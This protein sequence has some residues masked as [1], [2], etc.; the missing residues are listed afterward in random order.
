MNDRKV[1]EDSD[2]ERQTKKA[3]QKPKA[4]ERTRTEFFCKEHGANHSHNSKDCKVLNDPNRDTYKKKPN[5]PD[6]YKDYKSKYQKK[7]AELNLLQSETKKEKAKWIKAYNKL[8]ASDSESS[9]GG[10]SKKSSD[11]Q[12]E[13]KVYNV[14][15]SSSSSSSSDSESE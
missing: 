7:H 9:T 14:E 2:K 11:P 4:R 6:K 13:T 1:Y 3:K 5:N 10:A 15:C 8:K 12:K